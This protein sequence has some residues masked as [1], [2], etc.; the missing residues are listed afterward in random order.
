MGNYAPTR[1]QVKRMRRVERSQSGGLVRKVI[2][3]AK[4]GRKWLILVR[5]I[6]NKRTRVGEWG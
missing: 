5:I 2:R 1:T 4:T 3:L 6:G